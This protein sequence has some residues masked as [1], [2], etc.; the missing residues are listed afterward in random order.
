MRGTAQGARG[1][2][3]EGGLPVGGEGAV[4]CLVCFIPSLCL[5]EL[6]TAGSQRLRQLGKLWL[7]LLRR[8]GLSNCSVGAQQLLTDL[9]WHV[10]L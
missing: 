6:D 4:P 10:C 8:K 9:W 5:P 2:A 7:P 1:T 3:I